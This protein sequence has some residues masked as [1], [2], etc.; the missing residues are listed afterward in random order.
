MRRAILVL[1]ALLAA[2]TPAR[3]ESPKPSPWN[4]DQWRNLPVQDGGRQKPLD[5]LAWETFRTLS[6]RTSFADPQTVEPL[7]STA[8]YLAM[9]FEWPGW[10]RPRQSAGDGRRAACGL[11]RL[12]GSPTSGTS[13]GCCW[14]TP[15]SSAATWECRRTRSTFRLGSSARR[16]SATRRPARRLS[17]SPGPSGRWTANSRARRRWKES[18]WSWPIATGPTRTSAWASG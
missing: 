10:D 11:L 18:P 14:S 1:V 6:N 7:D 8:L 3:G 15:W 12:P 5:T 16:R 17:S 2:G 13:P 4:W 9:V